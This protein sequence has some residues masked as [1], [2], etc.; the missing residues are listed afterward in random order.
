MV[1]VVLT[2]SPT[3]G[4][5]L[6]KLLQ[7]WPQRPSAAAAGGN[8][9]DDDPHAVPLPTVSP[10]ARQP[11]T[12]RL[13]VMQRAQRGSTRGAALSASDRRVHTHENDGDKAVVVEKVVEE[14]VGVGRAVPLGSAREADGLAQGSPQGPV[15]GQGQEEDHVERGHSDSNINTVLLHQPHPLPPIYPL[16]IYITQRW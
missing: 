14:E 4:T 13:S 1:A 2:I 8:G 5:D 9:P 10:G 6:W 11:S 16:P 7:R 15:Q 12:L 3:P